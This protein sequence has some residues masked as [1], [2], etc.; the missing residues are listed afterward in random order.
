MNGDKSFTNIWETEKLI[1]EST[2][3]KKDIGTDIFS[4]N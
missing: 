2:E 4:F 3:I 1:N